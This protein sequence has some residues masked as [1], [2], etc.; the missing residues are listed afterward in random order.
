MTTLRDGR[1]RTG[2]N[3][4]TLKLDVG[5]RRRVSGGPSGTAGIFFNGSTGADRGF[6][7]LFD[8]NHVG[9]WGASA[10]WGFLMNVINGNVGIGTVPTRPLDVRADS[11]GIKLGL[12]GNGGGQLILANN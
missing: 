12:E 8:D 11:G 3:N 10:G 9:F 7:G 6:T 5:H 4:P 2:I 1:A